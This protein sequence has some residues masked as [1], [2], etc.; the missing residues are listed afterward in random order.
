M[1]LKENQSLGRFWLSYLKVVETI[2]II[3]MGLI[4]AVAAAQVFF[5]YAVGASLFW[6][7]ELM[8]YLMIWLVFLTA[9]VAYSRGELLGMRMVVDALPHRLRNIVNLSGRILIL[10][11]LFVVA[12]Y[13]FDFAYRT[14][15]QQAVALQ[16]S[17]FWVHVSIAAGAMLLAVHVALD[18]LFKR[19][20][21]VRESAGELM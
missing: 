13:G 15:F 4:V 1:N 12:F 17:L 19:H 6:S 21:G 18:D 5:R 7:E 10:I 3:G 9:G 16:F 14:R 2:A 11:F 20:F 8:R